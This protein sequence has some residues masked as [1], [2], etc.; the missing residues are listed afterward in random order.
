MKALAALLFLFL[1]CAVFPLQLLVSDSQI[2][3]E[4]YVLAYYENG[5]LFEGNGNVVNPSGEA[6][7]FAIRAGQA[8]LNA[9][10]VGEWRVEVEGIAREAQVAD[11]EAKAGRGGKE[12]DGGIFIF[13][14]VL[15]AV[16]GAGGIVFILRRALLGEFEGAQ[17]KEK[18]AEKKRKL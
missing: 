14:F 5:T 11:E 6:A 3:G 12:G 18:A 10:E 4:I 1:S 15:L 7:V 8:K 9:S 2:G 16:L 17:T 13:L